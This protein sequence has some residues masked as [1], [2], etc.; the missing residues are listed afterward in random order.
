[1]Q[2]TRSY[3]PNG[4]GTRSRWQRD[5]RYRINEYEVTYAHQN[6]RV[7]QRPRDWDAPMTSLLDDSGQNEKR[8]R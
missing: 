6:Q 1:M 3:L 2:H 8:M 7:H 5:K 4:R